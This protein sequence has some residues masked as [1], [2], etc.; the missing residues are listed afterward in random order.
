MVYLSIKNCQCSVSVQLAVRED[1]VFEGSPL[2][3][4]RKLDYL[5]RKKLSKKNKP[6]PMVRETVPALQISMLSS[7]SI[8]RPERLLPCRWLD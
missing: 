2:R 6:A 4:E 5:D 7:Y 8:R 3:L 1:V